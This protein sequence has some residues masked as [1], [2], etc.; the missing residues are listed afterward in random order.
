MPPLAR[1]RNQA[2]AEIA[3]QL[4][5]APPAALRRHI[6]R[7][8]ELA[9]DLDQ[10]M[11]YPEDWL[12]YRL[13]GYRP[14]SPGISAIPG[15]DLLGDLSALVERL[16]ETARLSPDDIEE[17]F[18]DVE[19]LCERW[20]VTRKSVERY[21]RQGLVARRVDTGG[22]GRRLV[23]AP[24]VVEA[25][26]RRHAARLRRAA[27]FS[28]IPA[29]IE[30]KMVRRAERYRRAGCTLNEAA[31]RIA[32][33]YGRSHEAVRQLLRRENE[34]RSEPLFTEPGPPSDRD[35]RMI[36]RAVRRGIEPS[37][38]ANR[39]G[40]SKASVL[41]A[42]NEHR[43]ELL[44]GLKLPTEP[45][46]FARD[47]ER[48]HA[49][50]TSE[51]ATSGLGRCGET[52]LLGFLEAAR[53][54]TPPTVEEERGR[55]EAYRLLRW[56]AGSR[57]A[58]L[59]T[60]TAEAAWLDEIETDL[61][62]AGRLKAELVRTQLPHMVAT[63][64]SSGEARLE[65]MAAPALA[66]LI[67]RGIAAVC[68]AVDR[69]DPSHGS[70]LAASAGMA[71]HKVAAERAR[72]LASARARPGRAMRRLTHGMRFEDWT[73]RVAPWQAWLSP[74]VRVRSVL[75]Q[76][77]ERDRAMLEL[78]FGLAGGPPR[79][80]DA[81]AEQCGVTR[82]HAAK[83]ERAAVRAALAA[84]RGRRMPPD[85]VGSAAEAGDGADTICA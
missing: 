22:G 11:Q 69:F 29:E 57:I 47:A 51:H 66:K 75:D 58:S 53:R 12:L 49:V 74:D 68:G 9:A 61:R 27:G 37:A 48:V 40:R 39:T 67:E 14:E 81:V 31:Q 56:R 34:R 63:L 59:S 26:E 43:A 28:R 13:T 52:D 32:G 10:A 76:L 71:V 54:R 84:A 23:F 82:M 20:N 7:A 83:W 18:L 1:I 30:A 17:S 15:D 65:E 44:R 80:L 21:R 5:F 45:P 19:G 72:E 78:R 25:F 73:W 24:E 36:L 70:R 50:L 60:T 79:T 8:E 2:V 33:R 35:R 38:I 42:L 64:E 55:A 62:W 85:A 3:A 77:H 4:R 16:S 41:R 46:V 6:A